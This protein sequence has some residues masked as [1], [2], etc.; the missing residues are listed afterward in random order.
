MFKFKKIASVASSVLMIGA[1]VA[2]AAAANYPAPFVQNGS[3]DVAVVYGSAA[4]SS[5]LVATIDVNSNLQASLSAQSGTTGTTTTTSGGDSITLGTSSRRL[6][7]GDPINASRSSLSSS[8][9]P[10]VLADGTFT[11]LGGTQY[12]YT[13]SINLGGTATTFGTSG[14]DL[15]DPTLYLDVGTSTSTP[16]FNYTLSFNKNLNLS[17]STNVQGQK[18]KILGIDYV[19]GATSDPANLYLYGAGQSVVINGGDAPK[20]LSIGSQSHT[21][22]LVS[23]SSATSA[24]IIFDGVSK[25]VSKGSSYSF[26]GDINVYVKDITHPAYQG[27]IRNVELII[28][29]NTLQIA[30]G[31]TVKYGADATSM[32]GTRGTIVA[33]GGNSISG[34]NVAVVKNRSQTDHLSIGD[35]FTDPVFGGF[36]VQFAAATPN[37]NDSARGVIKVRTDNNQYGYITF[38]SARSG[39]SGAKEITYA[40][41]NATSSTTVAPLLAHQTITSANRGLILVREGANAQTND[42]IVV[43]QGDSGTILEVTDITLNSGTEGKVTFQDAITGEQQTITLANSTGRPIYEKTGVNFFGGN[44]YTVRANQAGTTV[45]ISWSTSAT[46]TL[47]PR[48]KLKD[49][50]WLALLADTVVL[51]VSSYILPDGQT[52]LATTGTSINTVNRT[53]YNSVT[54]N[55]I[56]WTFMQTDTS[57]PGNLDFVGISGTNSGTSPANCNFTAAVGPAVLFLEPK[58]WDDSS[59]GNFVCIPLTT[60]GSTEVAVG[61]A[62]FNGTTSGYTTLTSDTY[63]KQ[64]VDK[65]GT[66][67]QKEDRTNEN[68]V[69]T[70]WYPGSQMYFDILFTAPSTTVVGGSSG[71]KAVS[72]L[73]SVTV[74]DSDVSMVSSKNMIVVGGSCVNTVAAS[75]LGSTRPLCGADFTSATT[76]GAGQFLIQSFTSPFSPSKVAVLVAGYNADD[77]TNAVKYLTTQQVDT[78]VKKKYVGTSATSAQLVTTTS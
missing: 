24:K 11:D 12:K 31:S 45:N 17:Y 41:D 69:V 26:A 57:N 5:D 36:K 52:T 32:T 43:N 7:Y 9:L 40:Y 47:F 42:W 51:N 58:K 62:Q 73:G 14:G 67:V 30:N 72:S 25:T 20:A 61:D 46:Q 65:F 34:F 29:A 63:V 10:N 38:N 33:A 2:L 48:I 54:A 56:N 66:F 39:T 18:I 4:A 1:T 53:A 23:T 77:T 6:Y 74:K 27:D 19:I 71:N 13:Q 59:Y 76:V 49:G 15:K 44:G 50:G 64:A 22:E 37:L 35:A 75:L 16:L 70:I 68:G 60:T 21:V 3:A 55:G 28:G 8:E 78:M